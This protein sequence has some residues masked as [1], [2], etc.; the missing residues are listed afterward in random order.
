ML[1]KEKKNIGMDILSS[2]GIRFDKYF[3]SQIDGPWGGGRYLKRLKGDHGP[4]PKRIMI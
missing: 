4:F 3:P 2:S 1:K